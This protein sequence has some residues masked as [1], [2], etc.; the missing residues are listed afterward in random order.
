MIEYWEKYAGGPTK[1]REERLHVTIN[2]KCVIFLNRNIHNL[3]SNAKAVVLFFNRKDG[4]I[5]IRPANE[6]LTEAFPVHDKGGYHVINASPFCRHFGIKVEA[7]EAFVNPEFDD[8]GTLRLNLAKTVS[9][10]HKK[11]RASQDMV[12]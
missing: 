8:T 10:V 6:R 7:T 11:R 4:V 5:G 2:K 9:V 3:L 12:S 1:P